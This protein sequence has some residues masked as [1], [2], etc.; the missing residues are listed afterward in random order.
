[1]QKTFVDIGLAFIEGLGLIASPC[2]LP[3][4]PIFLSS[5]LAGSKKR[6]LGIIVGFVLTFALFT[7]FTRELVQ[8][9]GINS[10]AIRHFSYFLLALMGITMMSEFLSDK[11]SR[12]TRG[13]S[14]VGSSSKIINNPA[15]GFGSG[16]LFGALIGLIW[17]PCA[18]LILGAVITQI[19]LQKSS[20]GSFF[21]LLAFG[22]GAGVPMLLIALFGRYLMARLTF[23]KTHSMLIRKILG[24]IILASVGLMVYQESFSGGLTL[25]S[26]D[27]HVNQSQLSLQDGITPYPAPPIVDP[28]GWINTSPLTLSDFKGKVV[29]LDFWTYSCINCVRTLPYVIGWYEK[30]HS[31]GLEVIGIHTPEFDFEKDLENVK[32][33]VQKYGIKYPV[34]LDSH[35]GTWQS[36]N[37]KY[38]PAQYLINKNGEVVYQ[39]FGEGG[40]DVMENNILFLLGLNDSAAGS[41]PDINMGVSAN[42]TPETYLGTNRASNY[43]S[44]EKIVPGT[45]S[46]YTFPDTLKENDWALQGSWAISPEYISA[47]RGNAAIKIRFHAKNVYVV[48][49]NTSGK[50][51]TVAVKFNGE[52]VTEDKGKDVRNSQVQVVLHGLYNVLSFPAAD[53]GVLELMTDSA[54]L[55]VYTFTFG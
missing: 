13:L 19:I 1:M 25:A 40:D 34:V 28:T 41:G 23:F 29:L 18:G 21:V 44:P 35:F 48:M 4:L 39:H 45:A 3:I 11:F 31:K 50:P 17:T 2:I 30:Y 42:L 15:G 51:I 22:L 49:G 52:S 32:A 16:M 12:M 37:N 33:A 5:S 46:D 43:S 10:N 55:D 9:S 8:L 38:W 24:A 7:Y 27:N 47:T 20:A 14:N 6:P 53:N 26:N 36:Y 54:G